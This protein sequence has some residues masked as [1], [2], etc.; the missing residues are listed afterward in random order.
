MADNVATVQAIYAAFGRG[1]VP[2]I[3]GHLAEDVVW[4]HDWGGAPLPLYQPRRGRNQ[5]PGFFAE[6]AAIEITRFE[7]LNLLTGGN[8]VV[9]VIRLEA[10]ARAT[11]RKVTDL[12]AHLWTF[13]ADGKVTAFRHL[14]D[15]RQHGWALGL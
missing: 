15:T 3:L 5:V 4:E 14:A 1:D 7:P 6:L 2:G 12:E 13:G 11:G 8:Q 10:T 9:A